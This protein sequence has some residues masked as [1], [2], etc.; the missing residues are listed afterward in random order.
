M[1]LGGRD[2]LFQMQMSLCHL[3]LGT[4]EIFQLEGIRMKGLA[5]LPTSQGQELDHGGFSGAGRGA[6]PAKSFPMFY[7][8][9]LHSSGWEKIARLWHLGKKESPK[10]LMAARLG[11]ALAWIFQG[12][13]EE[14]TSTKPRVTVLGAPAKCGDRAGGPNS[15]STFWDSPGCCPQLTKEQSAQC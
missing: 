10:E 4:L 8:E 15:A 13:D 6:G 12:W 9:V 2:E 7:P 3:P 1:I 5:G 11:W 14:I